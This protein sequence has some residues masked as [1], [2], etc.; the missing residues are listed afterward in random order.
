[1]IKKVFQAGD[2]GKKGK[3]TLSDLQ[4]WADKEFSEIGRAHV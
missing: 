1:M 4:S 2:Y 3:Y